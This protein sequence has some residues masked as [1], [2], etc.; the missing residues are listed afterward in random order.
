MSIATEPSVRKKAGCQLKGPISFFS[1]YIHE[2]LF[3]ISH[4]SKAWGEAFAH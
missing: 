4:H 2:Y 3:G 1:F